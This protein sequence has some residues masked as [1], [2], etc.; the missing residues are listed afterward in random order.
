MQRAVALYTEAAE[1]GHARAKYER[2]ACFEYGTGVERD[3]QKAV[4][5]YTEP[6]K[7]GYM[8]E[9]AEKGCSRA[10]YELGLLP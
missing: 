4:P 6:A 10:K 1:E 9:A 8:T 2:A 7:E 5:L 3:L